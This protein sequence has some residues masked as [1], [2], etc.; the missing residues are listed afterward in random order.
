M[1]IIDQ[2][3]NERDAFPWS[4]EPEVARFLQVLLEMTDRRSVLEL[5]TFKGATTI[6]LIESGAQVVTVDIED[7]TSPLFLHHYGHLC[8]VV[9]SDSRTFCCEGSKFDFIFFDTVHELDHVM[10]EFF[11][12]RKC[13]SDNCILAFHDSILFSGVKEFVLLRESSNIIRQITL[14]T[15]RG[16]GLTLATL[17]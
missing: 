2:I 13:M 16:S 8:T 1:D 5:G 14:P 12:L 3:Y 15:P 6:R 7:K 17:R 4:T 9:Q 11:H 10:A